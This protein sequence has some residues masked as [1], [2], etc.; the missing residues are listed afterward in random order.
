MDKIKVFYEN[1]LKY[2]C[3]L[4]VTSLSDEIYLY[5]KSLYNFICN[6][7]KNDL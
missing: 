2:K 3:I 7:N 5:L 4:Y 1:T 6:S